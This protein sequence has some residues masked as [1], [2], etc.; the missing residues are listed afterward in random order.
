MTINHILTITLLLCALL[1]A[2]YIDGDTHKHLASYC[3][4][5]EPI[6]A[7]EQANF[8]AYCKD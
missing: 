6:T 5:Q 4:S 7:A 1:M 2:G 3:D 8:N